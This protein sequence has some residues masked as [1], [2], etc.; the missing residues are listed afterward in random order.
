[1]RWTSAGSWR[2]CS[3]A[4]AGRRAPHVALPDGRSILEEFSRGL[5]LVDHGATGAERLLET[6]AARGV[7]MRHLELD[8]SAPSASVYERRLVLVRPDG[9]V[10]WRGDSLP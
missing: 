4:G 9:H 10:A 7:P 6:A 5:T 3:M 2:R 8:S 1:M